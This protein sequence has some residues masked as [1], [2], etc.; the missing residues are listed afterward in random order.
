MKK[1]EYN[2]FNT[3]VTDATGGKAVFD[4]EEDL[5]LIHIWLLHVQIQQVGFMILKESMLTFL[6]KLRKLRELRCV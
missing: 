6:K 2:E 1:D 4:D 3:K 5:S